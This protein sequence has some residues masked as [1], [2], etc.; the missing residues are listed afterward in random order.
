L[1]DIFAVELQK[2]GLPH[3]HLLI[4]LGYDF[5]CHSSQDVDSIVLLRYLTRTWIQHVM[6]QFMFYDAR[7]VANPNS[8]CMK[9]RKCSKC[10]PKKKVRQTLMTTDLCIIDYKD[11]MK[12]LFLKM[13]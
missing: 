5:K 9:H 8:K 10:F 11:N 13:G 4:W 2:R 1:P 12:G 3:C 7:G 6:T